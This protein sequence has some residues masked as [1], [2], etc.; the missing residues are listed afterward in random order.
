M[1]TGLYFLFY[2][3]SS[4]Q[5]NS[6]LFFTITWR[7]HEA[8]MV[9]LKFSLKLLKWLTK[10]EMLNLYHEVKKH[11]QWNLVCVN[12]SLCSLRNSLNQIVDQLSF[13]A[14]MISLQFLLKLLKWLTKN[15]ML[16]LDHEVK[17]HRQWNLVCVNYASCSFRNSLNQIV[18]QLSFSKMNQ[19]STS[20]Y[21][22]IGRYRY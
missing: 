20:T 13:S 5:T 12:Y 8:V 19:W 10:N 21:F 11:R 22:N 4:F 9:S 7:L 1:Q 3:V 14:A 15:D 18:N 6:L 16:N 2:F 17:K